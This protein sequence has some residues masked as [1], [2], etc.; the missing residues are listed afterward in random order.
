CLVHK[1]LVAAGTV[2]TTVATE[3]ARHLMVNKAEAAVRR[4]GKMAAVKHQ[5]G[6][7]VAEVVDTA[8]NPLFL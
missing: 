3:A 8:Y 4:T 2:H 6:K 7:V 1:W 5:A